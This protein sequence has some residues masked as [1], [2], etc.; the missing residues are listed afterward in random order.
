MKRVEFYSQHQ[1]EIQQNNNVLSNLE[2][3]FFN[4]VYKYIYS[5]I[6]YSDVVIREK[7]N[8]KCS[9]RSHFVSSHLIHSKKKISF[10]NI[11]FSLS[12][13]KPRV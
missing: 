4:G 5:N 6:T 10:L 1:E 3:Q 9:L 2:H 7:S 12:V 11:Y 13:Y 8:T